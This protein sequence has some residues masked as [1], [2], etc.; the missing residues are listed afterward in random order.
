MYKKVVL[1]CISCT[2]YTLDVHKTPSKYFCTQDILS[3]F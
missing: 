3:S 2:K 1:R